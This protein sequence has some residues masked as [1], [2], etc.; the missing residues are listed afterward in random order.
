[1]KRD[2]ERWLQTVSMCCGYELWVCAVGMSWGHENSTYL[3]VQVWA[4]CM[5]TTPAS[6][7]RRE[8]ESRV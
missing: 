6:E 2:V 5:R 8:A 1:M 4:V 3:W 7:A